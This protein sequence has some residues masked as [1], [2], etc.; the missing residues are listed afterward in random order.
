MAMQFNFF[1]P[2]KVARVQI[3][4]DER[5]HQINSIIIINYSAVITLSDRIRHRYD[6]SNLNLLRAL[7][8]AEN[9]QKQQYKFKLVY[10]GVDGKKAQFRFD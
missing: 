2:D 4:Q 3:L 7:K 1:S 9:Y 6:L 10:F 8:T 5:L